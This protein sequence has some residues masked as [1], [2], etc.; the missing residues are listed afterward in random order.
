MR[1]LEKLLACFA[2]KRRYNVSRAD[3]SKG[4]TNFVAP[5]FLLGKCDFFH[6]FFDAGTRLLS[7]VMVVG[8]QKVMGKF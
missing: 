3:E 1:F 5:L 6:I 2:D 7:P 8:V 4:A